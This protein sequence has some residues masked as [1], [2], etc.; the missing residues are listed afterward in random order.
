GWALSRAFAANRPAAA[1]AAATLAS[2]GIIANLSFGVWQEWWNATIFVAA[3]LVAALA[4][5]RA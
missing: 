5:S 1:A 3:A 4:R 2:L